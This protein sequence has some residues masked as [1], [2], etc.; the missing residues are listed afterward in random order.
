MPK[1]PILTRTAVFVPVAGSG[2]AAASNDR[3]HI[4]GPAGGPTYRRYEWNLVT[5]SL[6]SMLELRGDDL[7]AGLQLPL[8]MT[9]EDVFETDV[10]AVKILTH[11]QLA[12]MGAAGA[13]GGGDT[14]PRDWGKAGQP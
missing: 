12:Q 3:F 4:R 5:T 14:L 11:D 13:L 2:G 10:N 9:N 6:G 7:R 8:G 1:A